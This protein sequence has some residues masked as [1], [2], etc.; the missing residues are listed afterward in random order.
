MKKHF[1]ISTIIVMLLAVG[2]ITVLIFEFYI[3]SQY[4]K[5]IL[6]KRIQQKR[7]IYLQQL[8]NSLVLPMKNQ[9]SIHI[10]QIVSSY[11][12]DPEV[13]KITIKSSGFIKP[14]VNDRVVQQYNSVIKRWFGLNDSIFTDVSDVLFNQIAIGQIELRVTNQIAN[15]EIA[16]RL[17]YLLVFFILLGAALTGSLFYLQKILIINPVMFLKRYADNV[18]RNF[19]LT[20]YR[21]NSF[22]AKELNELL[23]SI[24]KMLDMLSVRYSMLK[25]TEQRY[26]D[27]LDKTPISI[28]VEDVS[29][30][31]NEFE[32]LRKQGVTDVEAYLNQSPDN[33]LSLIG[34][35]KVKSINHAS[36]QL[37]E[38]TD[39][40][41]LINR[42]TETYTPLSFDVL[43]RCMVALWNN[44]REF[45]YETEYKSLKGNQIY[46][47][48]KW[49]I[50][51]S[52]SS[53]DY[54][55]VTISDITPQKHLELELK[56]QNE[57]YCA[58]NEEILT[59]NRHIL[60]INKELTIA[61][62]QAEESN[63]L[64]IAFLCNMSHEIRTPLNAIVGFSD[65]LCKENDFDQE[66]NAQYLSIIQ[67][68]GNQ[69]L[70]IVDDILTISRVQTGQE[71]V[72]LESVNINSV[73]TNLYPVFKATADKKHLELKLNLFSTQPYVIS[74]DRLKLIQIIT[75]LLNNALK[76][77]HKGYV[78]YGC[79]IENYK[80]ILYVKDTGIGIP[81][82]AQKIIFERFAQADKLI[83][84]NYGGTG[85]GLSICRSY[86]ELLNATIGLESKV[87][88]GSMFRLVI[89]VEQV[90]NAEF[91]N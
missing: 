75:N 51:S 40:V 68:N 87:N 30:I 49:S 26:R 19:D 27:M 57:S 46:A 39:S 59:S 38:A 65:L 5:L 43:K 61:K 73:L 17:E 28:W 33:M 34:M 62:E 86:A 76:F 36:C 72:K 74:T 14:S 84:V 89:P 13:Y 71:S 32:E 60:T 42:I 50:V 16:K 53:D 45:E 66:V 11:L 41:E 35:I 67:N 2:F 31:M 15:Y 8:A 52:L 44:C 55:L 91:I 85:L 22:N 20:F 24:G 48:L 83:A 70:G 69:L 9:D 54:L 10:S 21:P 25:E 90:A 56:R 18:C 29:G 80:L 3:S 82:A 4:D 12:I 58:L 37:F 23:L 78:E 47:I 6:E 77:T 7:E 1:S 64:K 63:R 88:E 81:E 79:Y